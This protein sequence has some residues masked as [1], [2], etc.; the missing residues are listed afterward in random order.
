[1][2]SEEEWAYELTFVERTVIKIITAF[3]ASTF[4][5]RF[6]KFDVMFVPE[7]N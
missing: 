6:D 2:L 7:R 3:D 4:V 1:M 5:G